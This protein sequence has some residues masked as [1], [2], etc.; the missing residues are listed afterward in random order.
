MQLAVK[1]KSIKHK[2]I[3]TKMF[4]S[5]AFKLL[6][7]IGTTVQNKLASNTVIS[8]KKIKD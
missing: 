5:N 7:H 8:L 6:L 4:G 2:S 1:P 3:V